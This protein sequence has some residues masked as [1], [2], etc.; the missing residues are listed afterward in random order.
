M[1]GIK[2]LEKYLLVLKSRSLA[3]FNGEKNLM[4]SNAEL[5]GDPA[6]SG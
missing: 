4:F 5:Q 6:G 3:L 1:K 2:S